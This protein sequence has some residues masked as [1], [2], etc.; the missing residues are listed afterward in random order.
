MGLIEALLLGIQ[1]KGLQK[2]LVFFSML[3]AL[4]MFSVFGI[5]II[6]ALITSIAT[7]DKEIT[8]QFF[9]A[10]FGM[11]V[12]SCVFFCLAWVCGYFIKRCFE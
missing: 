5:G 10:S 6:W 4:L 7:T 2:P 11:L 12:I 9:G 1:F 8:L 3:I